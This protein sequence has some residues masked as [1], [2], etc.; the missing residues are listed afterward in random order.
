LSRLSGFEQCL[1]ITAARTPFEHS[2]SY[3]FQ[4]LKGNLGG[5]SNKDVMDRFH[6]EFLPKRQREDAKWFS[7]FQKDFGVDL[8]NRGADVAEK[9]YGYWPTSGSGCAVLLL[10]FEDISSWDSILSKV[11]PRWY[12]LPKKNISKKAFSNA[13]RFER[14]RQ[15][16]QFSSQEVE[17]FRAY[18]SWNFY[19]KAE[20]DAVMA[21][22]T[23]PQHSLA[24]SDYT[25]GESS[26]W[27][28]MPSNGTFARSLLMSDSN[29]DSKEDDD[30][31]QPVALL[32]ASLQTIKLAHVQSGATQHNFTA[33]DEYAREDAAYRVYNSKLQGPNIP[34]LP[35]MSTTDLQVFAVEVGKAS[36]YLE[37]G[38]GGST[39]FVIKKDNIKK[40][41]TLESDDAWLK[42]LSTHWLIH[43]AIG[44]SRLTLELRNIGRTGK[45]GRPVND[46]AAARY[47]HYSDLPETSPSNTTGLDAHRTKEHFDLIFVD[48]RFRVACFL[49]ALRDAPKPFRLMIHDYERL[50][51]HVVERFAT[52]V[53]QDDILAVFTPKESIDGRELDAEIKKYEF[54]SA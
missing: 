3:S 43:Q 18:D 11:L 23:G 42:E 44:D 47:P 22:Y 34:A 45:W 49:K 50:E 41:H 19:T 21:E 1:V 39:A 35:H 30:E 40:M 36:T 6:S 37:W 12:G 32:Q 29:L 27:T 33:A 17:G 24:F 25:E 26:N 4:H 54:V 7:N 14:L 8:F 31:S 16:I 15:Q 2:V 28:I 20:K 9:G 53:K 5:M 46:H 38:S 51:Y 10:R 48:G 52:K 13:A